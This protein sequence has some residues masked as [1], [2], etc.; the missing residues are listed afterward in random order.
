MTTQTNNNKQW[1]KFNVGSDLSVINKVIELLELATSD[2]VYDAQEGTITTNT[3]TKEFIHDKVKRLGFEFLLD[4]TKIDDK[5]YKTETISVEKPYTCL[6]SINIAHNAVYNKYK[7][8]KYKTGLTITNT[9][10]DH[11]TQ[12]VTITA[13]VRSPTF[14]EFDYK[15]ALVLINFSYVN[16]TISSS[17]E[18]EI[19]KLINEAKT[20]FDKVVP[21]ELKA[22][23]RLFPIL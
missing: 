1:F 18:D 5:N 2:Y 14:N 7:Q 10:I 19:Y 22:F 8:Y 20:E 16:I 12:T 6:N 3:V 15:V 4:P 9:N 21:E 17:A 13:T 23:I 11:I